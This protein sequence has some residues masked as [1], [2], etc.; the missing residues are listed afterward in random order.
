MRISHIRE[1]ERERERTLGSRYMPLGSLVTNQP[2]RHP[3]TIHLFDRDPS[4]RTGTSDPKT[5]IGT[6]G[7]FPKARCPYTSSAIIRILCFFAVSAI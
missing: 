3:G 5:P 1:R 7:F 2:S 6:N 4:V